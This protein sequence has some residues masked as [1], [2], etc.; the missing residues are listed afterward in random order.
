MI[1]TNIFCLIIFFSKTHGFRV[2]SRSKAWRSGR[3]GPGR[4]DFCSGWQKLYHIWVKQVQ[5]NTFCSIQ[6]AS[7]ML[8]FRVRAIL[9]FCKWNSSTTTWDKALLRARFASLRFARNNMMHSIAI[10]SG[11]QYKIIYVAVSY[12]YYRVWLIEISILTH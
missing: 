5:P 9:R 4:V 10:V 1:Q 6:H 7:K 2:I 11:I 8:S 12:L 3:A